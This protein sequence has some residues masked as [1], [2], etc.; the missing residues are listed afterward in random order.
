MTTTTGTTTI[1]NATASSPSTNKTFSEDE[2]TSTSIHDQP[3]PQQ[4]QRPSNDDLAID[5]NN[6]V[7][8]SSR[9]SSPIV[10]DHVILTKEELARRSKKLQI[11]SLLCDNSSR[12]DAS[13][14]TEKQL[15]VRDFDLLK[16]TC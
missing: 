1:T 15:K 10:S 11:L 6:V 9:V 12:F 13:Y 2:S 16:T 5:T 4:P 14:H 7:V 8:V 3:Q